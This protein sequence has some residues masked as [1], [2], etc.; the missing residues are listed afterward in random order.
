MNQSKLTNWLKGPSQGSSSNSSTPERR[1]PGSSK[2]NLSP[3]AQKRKDGL[4]AV[5]AETK[6]IL[7]DILAK[8][9]AFNT[10]VSSK[11]HRDTLRHLDPNGCPGFELPQGDPQ[12]GMKGTRIRVHD[13]DTYDAAL[14]LQP[15]TTVSWVL[16]QSASSGAST[17]VNAPATSTSDDTKMA[18]DTPAAP[19][20]EDDYSK[21]DIDIQ[22]PA[23]LPT[24]STAP[25][26][27]PPSHTNKPVA[28]LNLASERNAGGGWENGAIA[29]EEALCY[30]S[31][32]YL[33]LHRAYYPLKQLGTIYS[34]N[35]L[36]I[37]DA[38]SRGH[39]LLF[40]ATAAEDLPVTSVITLAAIRRPALNKDGTYAKTTDREFTKEKIRVVLRVAAHQGH[41]KLVLGALGCGAFHNPPEEVAQCFLEVFREQEFTGGW[42]EDIVFAVLDNAKG[43]KGGKDGIGNFGVFYRAL[44]AE[45]V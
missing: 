32:L 19:K 3:A 26:F 16:G 33:S 34:P 18:I 45:V 25:I 35:V 12:A 40:P 11:H 24:N 31:S 2:Y 29:Q 13:Q 37:R 21:M 44:D 23:P 1:P 42:W 4:R 43:D 10:G 9:S 5:C 30:R 6:S 20:D 28:V 27:V 39:D 38:M 41:R 17:A 36:I 15:K 22:S 7:P 8:I 14:E